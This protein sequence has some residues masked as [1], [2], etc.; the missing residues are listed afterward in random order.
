MIT[1]Q[2]LSSG[3]SYLSSGM[4]KDE[5][6]NIIMSEPEAVHQRTEVVHIYSIQGISGLTACKSASK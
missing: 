3:M 2:Y 4:S 1:E 5:L 6:C